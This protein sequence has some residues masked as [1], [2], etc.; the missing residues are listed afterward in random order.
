MNL[1]HI[2]VQ[3]ECPG[4]QA[5]LSG[6]GMGMCEKSRLFVHGKLVGLHLL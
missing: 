5:G 6:A 3:W 2:S 1:E 4:E